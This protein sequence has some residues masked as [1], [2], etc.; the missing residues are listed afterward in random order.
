M[1]CQEGETKHVENASMRDD[2]MFKEGLSLRSF[3]QIEAACKEENNAEVLLN[4][5]CSGGG[6][7]L[8]EFQQTGKFEREESVSKK[9]FSTL[10]NRQGTAILLNPESV[11]SLCDSTLEQIL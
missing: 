10:E 9:F 7:R 4:I 3:E 5:S 2:I 11:N 6:S 8:G 1:L